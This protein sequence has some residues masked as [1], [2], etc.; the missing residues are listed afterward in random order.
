MGIILERFEHQFIASYANNAKTRQ[1]F[2]VVDASALKCL[3]EI[4]ACECV[5]ML[6]IVYSKPNV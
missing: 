3:Q 6:F 1:L 2:I 5:N 4:Q